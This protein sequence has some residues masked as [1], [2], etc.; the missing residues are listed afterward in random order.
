MKKIIIIAMLA[1]LTILPACDSPKKVGSSNVFNIVCLGGIE[2]W[3]A[4]RGY[5]AVRISS[6]TMTYV[7]CEGN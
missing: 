1:A 4:K 7:K 3:K 2:Y 5:M 6:E